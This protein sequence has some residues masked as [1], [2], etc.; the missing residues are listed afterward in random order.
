MNTKILLNLISD[1]DVCFQ[2]L[3]ELIK[4]IQTINKLLIL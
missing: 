2:W 3:Q 4:Q 1:L